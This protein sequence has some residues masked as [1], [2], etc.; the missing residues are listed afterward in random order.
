MSLEAITK[1]RKVEADMEQAKADAKAQ[2][3]KLLA[4]TEREGRALLQQGKVRAAE[5][6]AEAMRQ[7]EAEAAQRREKILAQAE[8]DCRAL[9]AQADARMDKATQAILGRVV[10]S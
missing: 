4:D 10:G 2:V 6:A 1:I 8:E 9:R 5:K 3:Q 7:A